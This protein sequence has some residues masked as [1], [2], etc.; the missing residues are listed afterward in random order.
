MKAKTEAKSCD[1]VSCILN[2]VLAVSVSSLD[3][4]P[5]DFLRFLR[6]LGFFGFLFLFFLFL[7]FGGSF[8]NCGMRL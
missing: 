6:G 7:R 5:T 2:M 3:K 8:M 4:E 1:V